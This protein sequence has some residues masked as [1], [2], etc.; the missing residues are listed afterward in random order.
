MTTFSSTRSRSPRVRDPLRLI[1]RGS[2]AAVLAFA[3]AACGQ[4][5]QPVLPD[6]DLAINAPATPVVGNVETP[7]T[8]TGVNIAGDA[9]VQVGGQDATNVQ[10]TDLLGQ[11]VAA[12]IRT[13][14][15]ITFTPPALDDG[16]YD[17]IISQ[18]EDQSVTL[19]QA[20]TYQAVPDNNG[21]TDP[22]VG[23]AVLRINAGGPATT[24]MG[25]EWVADGTYLRSGQGGAAFP[26]NHTIQGTQNQEVYS[27][28]RNTG[29]FTNTLTYDIPL[30]DGTYIVRLH[31]AELFFGAPGYV[32]DFV[33]GQ[34]VFNVVAQ[35]EPRLT[36]YDMFVQSGGASVTAFT[37]DVT[38][39]VT[40]GTLVLSFIDVA[41]RAKV[42][43]IEIFLPADDNGTDSND[44]GNG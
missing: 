15:S 44:S 36:N 27:W 6:G 22:T 40:D 13:G 5:V 21:P 9:T 1:L 37:E 43:G 39:E 33:A 41:D 11:P 17:V 8:L 10:V 18:G 29:G 34:R 26:A 12:G 19:S 25:E 35:G 30:T 23:E 2:L 3:L 32:G 31:F 16:T 42:N 38:V 28:E 14:T 7:V 24:F 4:V 20:F